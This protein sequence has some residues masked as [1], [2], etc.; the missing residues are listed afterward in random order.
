MKTGVYPGS[1]DP[2]TFGHIDIIERAEKL[3]DE[4]IILIA[5]N[6]KKQALFS[7]EERKEIIKE[8][9]KEKKNIKVEV[10]DGLLAKYMKEKNHK[11][12]VRKQ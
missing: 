5:E 7:L 10:L 4:I 1:F 6:R 11:F 9:F 12:V 2:I 8:L 3:F